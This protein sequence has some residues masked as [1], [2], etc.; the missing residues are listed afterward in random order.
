MGMLQDDPYL[1]GQR[2][3][4][5]AFA[6]QKL[7]NARMITYDAQDG[8]FQITDVG[9]I[10]A[11]Y[12]IRYK[13]IEIFNESLV[14][15]MSEADVLAMISKSVEVRQPSH[16]SYLTLLINRLSL[17]RS[18]FVNPRLQSWRELWIVSLVKSR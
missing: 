15:K 14:P 9:R 2:N 8:Q 16:Y 5:T 4:L 6:A 1:G 3:E 11:K 17:T 12:Y 18:R 13:S 7:A 10:A